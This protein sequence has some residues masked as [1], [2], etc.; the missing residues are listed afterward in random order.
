MTIFTDDIEKMVD[1]LE[2]SK[3]EFLKSYSYITEEDYAETLED[4]NYDRAEN[5]AYMM[6]SAENMYIEE[7]NGRE[8]GVS[9]T[10][11]QVKQAVSTY[12]V[13]H[14]QQEEIDEFYEICES[15]AI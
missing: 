14:L 10:S 15:L 2:L 13:E 1:F 8:T 11:L 12:V 3:G 6:R 9:V 7:M 4:F 5:L